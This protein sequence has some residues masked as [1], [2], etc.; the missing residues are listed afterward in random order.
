MDAASSM[1][2][3]EETELWV[4]VGMFHIGSLVEL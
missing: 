4:V 3:A 1:L 2:L